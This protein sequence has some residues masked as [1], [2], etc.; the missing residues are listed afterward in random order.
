MKQQ[1]IFLV[2]L[3]F[4]L[5]VYAQNSKYFVQSVNWADYG[6]ANG[7]KLLQKPNNNF[8]IAGTNRDSLHWFPFLYE[9]NNVGE[10]I[11]TRNYIDNANHAYA[12]T[13]IQN[14]NNYIILGAAVP[15]DTTVAHAYTIK[16]T[17]DYVPIHTDF[18]S[19]TI[20]FNIISEACHTTDGGY[21]GAG[22]ANNSPPSVP[23]LVKLD[24]AGIYLWDRRYPEFSAGSPVAVRSAFRNIEPAKDGSGYYAAG[25]SK[26]WAGGGNVLLA[27]IADNGDIIWSET[28]DLTERDLGN[29][30]VETAD[31]GWLVVGRGKLSNENRGLI[32]KIKPD[33]S[34]DW[35]KT[36]YFYGGSANHVQELADGSFI[37]AGDYLNTTIVNVTDTYD[38]DT[39]ILKLSANGDFVWRRRIAAGNDDDYLY[40]MILAK[41]SSI[42]ICG[43]TESNL[44]DNVYANLYILKT[45]CMGL[46]TQ[47]QANFTTQMDT[48]LL[49]A[50]FQNLS[51][52]TYP[53]SIDGGH[54]LWD[55]GD[56]TTS[57]QINP[58]HT[59]AQG[60]NYTVT[61]TAVVC[62][63]TSVFVQEVSTWA[64]G[65]PVLPLEGGVRGGL[66]VYPNPANTQLNFVY[67]SNAEQNALVCIYDSK[68]SLVQT[69]NIQGNNTNTIDTN[70][71]QTGMYYYTATTNGNTTQR[72]KIVIIK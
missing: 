63:D 62:S 69:F 46:L 11:A 25:S 10:N 4:N 19:D 61:L 36:Q 29:A 67:K 37:I 13:I 71:W 44:P 55:F 43:R 56:G 32:I 49:T 9:F 39:E 31:G 53:D 24:T 14:E 34:V 6:N 21:F 23:Y 26:V 7:W 18:V 65:I 3:F 41:D 15:L 22:E 58:T 66:W 40:D 45:N 5:I 1:F 60:G 28:Y 30:V 33:R 48:T 35:Y 2:F 8:L 51:Q 17:L 20:D 50:T 57:N 12:Q 52:Y 68:G 54:Y 38:F 72:S 64:V 47:P 27:K 16:T 42:V 70:Q 59:Y